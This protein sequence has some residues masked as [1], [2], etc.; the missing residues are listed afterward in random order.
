MLMILSKKLISKILVVVMVFGSTDSKARHSLR[1]FFC[2]CVLLKESFK[3]FVFKNHCVFIV[4]FLRYHILIIVHEILI[5]K[6]FHRILF[7]KRTS[8]I[9]IWSCDNLFNLRNSGFSMFLLHVNGWW[10]SSLRCVH[11]ILRKEI[12]L[13]A[14]VWNLFVKCFLLTVWNLLL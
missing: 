13:T 1:F 11:Y 6:P 7:V 3:T 9:S 8:C 2:N 12:V 4:L 10:P 14:G 5:E